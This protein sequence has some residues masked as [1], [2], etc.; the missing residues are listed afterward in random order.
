MKPP[1]WHKGHPKRGKNEDYHHLFWEARDYKGSYE[2]E[3]RNHVGLVIPLDKQ[4]HSYLHFVVLPPPKFT[5]N[6]MADCM[7][8]VKQGQEYDAETN[9]F[10]GAGAVMRY[11]VF[12]EMDNPPVAERMHNIRYNLA[13][14]IGIMAGQH[15]IENPLP[16]YQEIDRGEAA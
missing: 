9:K 7:D 6:E 12:L 8:F 10:W 5:K 4:V 14:Q 1:S 16:N 13:Q 3:F 2:R 15:T 11:T